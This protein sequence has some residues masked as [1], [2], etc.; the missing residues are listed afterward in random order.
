MNVLP[1]W[2]LKD[3]LSEDEIESLNVKG[4]G[5]NKSPLPSLTAGGGGIDAG[6]GGALARVDPNS[7]DTP[8]HEASENVAKTDQKNDQKE[9]SPGD[10]VRGADAG[11][12]P[13][14][15]DKEEV[16]EELRDCC[17]RPSYHRCSCCREDWKRWT[18]SRRFS[19]R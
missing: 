5:Q 18:M 11:D 2:S 19:L 16:D 1:N 6:K 7:E 8:A 9:A 14:R 13:E 17:P 4:E 3:L 10:D 15:N 12:D